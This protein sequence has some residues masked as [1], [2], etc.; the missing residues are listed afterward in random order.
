YADQPNTAG[1]LRFSTGQLVHH[2]RTCTKAGVQA[3]FH[4]IGNAAVAQA[5]YAVEEVA[6]ELGRPAVRAC[7]HRLEHVE[8][9][10]P[11]D[12]DRMRDLGMVASVQPAFDAAWGGDAGM[13]AERLPARRARAPHPL[14]RLPHP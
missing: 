13:Y 7:R 5:I 14:P 10:D 2:V 3:G 12:V 1:T 6:A 9:I 8:L 4:A 11:V